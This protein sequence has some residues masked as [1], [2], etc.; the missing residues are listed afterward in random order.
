MAEKTKDTVVKPQDAHIT[1]GTETTVKPQDAHITGGSEDT[2]DDAHITG[3]P[4]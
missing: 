4:A 2:T 1:G 3:D